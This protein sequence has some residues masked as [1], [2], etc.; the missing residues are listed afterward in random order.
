[1]YLSLCVRESL[2]VCVCAC[3]CVCMCVSVCVRACVRPAFVHVCACTRARLRARVHDCVRSCRIQLYMQHAIADSFTGKRFARRWREH[4]CRQVRALWWDSPIRNVV[5]K[6]NVYVCIVCVCV[7][8]SMC[9]CVHACVRA[10]KRACMRACV[11]ARVRAFVRVCACVRVCMCVCVCVCVCA[12]MRR[13]WRLV[14]GLSSGPR[15]A[16]FR[17]H[18]SCCRRR[19]VRLVGADH[20]HCTVPFAA[21]VA[22]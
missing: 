12:H 4:Q 5:N 10:C 7:C 17:I 2:C 21:R 15:F 3:M 1:V 14:V 18:D 20:E 16:L 13:R 9:V 22:R 8:S 11:H 19:L 6:N